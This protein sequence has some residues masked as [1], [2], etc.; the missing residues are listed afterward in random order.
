ME[1]AEYHNMAALEGHFW[2]YKALH[3]RVAGQIGRLPLQAG[4]RV[5]DAGCGTGGLLSHLP[6][7]YPALQFTGLEHDA[8]A[9]A[10]AASKSAQPVCRGSIDRMPFAT[11]R[12]AA[13]LSQDVLYHRNVDE[14]AALRECLR[15][16]Q[17]GGWLLLNLPAFQWLHSSHDVH[18]HGARRY[19]AGRLRRILQQ[20]GFT[21]IRT[22]Y[23]NTLLFPLMMAQ[24]LTAGRRQTSSDVRALPAWQNA[25]LFRVLDSE[26]RLRLP[27][28]FGGSV[29]AEA[30]KP[31]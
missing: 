9:A 16:L 28:P 20:A 23:W 25:L 7:H 22:G 19:T 8:E 17:P 6:A 21:D 29:W 3:A 24:R 10:R 27:L 18:V 31:R 14:A 4:D 15:C 11:D 12:F 30:R 26:R 5:L 2:W 13:I 1:R